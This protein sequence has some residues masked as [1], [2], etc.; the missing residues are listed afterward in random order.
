MCFVPQPP[1]FLRTIRRGPWRGR[2]VTEC[3]RHLHFAL[4]D[5]VRRPVVQHQRRAAFPPDRQRHGHESADAFGAVFGTPMFEPRDVVEIVGN[6][7]RGK[8]DRRAL[9]HLAANA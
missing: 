4:G 6:E 9:D 7:R 5:S 3:D 1:F 8:W 2:E